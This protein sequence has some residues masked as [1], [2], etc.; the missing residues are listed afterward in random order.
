[1]SGAYLH[2]IKQHWRAQQWV[3]ETPLGAHWDHL[4]PLAILPFLLLRLTTMKAGNTSASSLGPNHDMVMASSI[5]HCL[6]WHG[7]ALIMPR[8][9]TVAPIMPQS[10]T[11]LCRSNVA[12]SIGENLLH[13]WGEKVSTGEKKKMGQEEE[14]DWVPGLLGTGRHITSTPVGLIPCWPPGWPLI[15]W[16][17]GQ[18]PSHWRS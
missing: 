8:D 17:P 9:D 6:S 5:C 11:P 4:Y 3:C 16:A 13:L 10:S 12:T 2:S 1:M 14:E 18:N 15:G 7:H